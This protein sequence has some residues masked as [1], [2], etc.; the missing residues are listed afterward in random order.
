M[1]TVGTDCALGKKYTALALAI[2]ALLAGATAAVAAAGVA[3]M[4]AALK[5]RFALSSAA[6]QALGAVLS[7]VTE[8]PHPVAGAGGQASA[9]VSRMNALALR[10]SSTRSSTSS[11]LIGRMPSINAPSPWPY[12]ACSAKRQA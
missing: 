10:C 4:I 6:W 1:L 2:A 5:L 8:K 7:M 9:Q 12:S 3:A 11:G